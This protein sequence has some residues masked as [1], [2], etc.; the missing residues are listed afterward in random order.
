MSLRSTMDGAGAAIDDGSMT[1]GGITAAAGTANAIGGRVNGPAMTAIA[2]IDVGMM[3]ID[4][5][6]DGTTMI[7]ATEIG[8]TTIVAI[9][10]GMTMTDVTGAGA[11]M[12]AT[13]AA[14]SPRPVTPSSARRLSG[15][16]T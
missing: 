6:E 15:E 10:V 11:R 7:A 14:R 5:I 13:G 1:G 16:R 3:T 9:E 4:A 12:I 8:T 2:M